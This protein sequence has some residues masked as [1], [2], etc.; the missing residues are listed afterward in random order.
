MLSTMQQEPIT[1]LSCCLWTYRGVNALDSLTTVQWQTVLLAMEKRHFR[2][3]EVVV[4]KVSFALHA[5]LHLVAH[6]DIIDF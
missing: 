4:H 5:I 3:G 2:A 1:S 6:L